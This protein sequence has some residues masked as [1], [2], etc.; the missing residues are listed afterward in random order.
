VKKLLVITICVLIATAGVIVDGGN[1][2][3]K[4]ADQ[5]ANRTAEAVE[6]IYGSNATFVTPGEDK[7]LEQYEDSNL[8]FAKLERHGRLIYWHHR[9]IDGAI[10]ELDRKVYMFDAEPGELIESEVPN[11]REDL[12]EHMTPVITKE[13]AEDIGGEKPVTL[14]LADS[15]Y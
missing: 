4:E 15:K 10:V 5:T 12:P 2:A 1:L 14:H 7:L 3:G 13:Q 11:W 9:I 6:I 8:S